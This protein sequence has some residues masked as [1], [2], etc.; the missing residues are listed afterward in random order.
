MKE[1]S[2][3]SDVKSRLKAIESLKREFVMAY[4]ESI[5]SGDINRIAQTQQ[6]KHDLV[7]EYSELQ[8][9]MDAA[10]VENL[11]HL[12]QQYRDQ[13]DLL[14]KVDMIDSLCLTGIDGKAY[15]LPSY[16]VIVERIAE[17]LD[18]FRMKADQGFTKLLLVPFGMSLEEMVKKMMRYVITFEME[19]PHALSADTFMPVSVIDDFEHED[20]DGGLVYDVVAFDPTK[21]GGHTKQEWL[22]EQQQTQSPTAGW[23]ILFC[24]SRK[25]GKGIRSIPEQGSGKTDGAPLPR[26][27]I[28][29]GQLVREYLVHQ[30]STAS[31]EESPYFG[32]SGVATEEWFMM[33][34]RHLEETLEPLDMGGG[35]AYSTSWLTGSYRAKK[36]QA[37]YACWMNEY[38]D[39]NDSFLCLSSDDNYDSTPHPSRGVRFVVRV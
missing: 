22:A 2:V 34:M 16:D 29:R 7:E 24:Q 21:H 11:F 9:I 37:L 17:R 4:A 36:D 28:E 25:D 15:P 3:C 6:L 27:E 13:V 5:V 18:F 33:F 31:D 10:S 26:K 38:E 35:G 32:E 1:H 12:R 23:H 14:E 20:V 30:I 39:E 8:K 19:H